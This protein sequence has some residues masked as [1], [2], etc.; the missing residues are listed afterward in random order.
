M[1]EVVLRCGPSRTEQRL[2]TYA[3]SY[4]QRQLRCDG[5]RLQPKRAWPE[6][7]IALPNWQNQRADIAGF[8]RLL[9]KVSSD[10][11]FRLSLWARDWLEG[12]QAAVELLNRYQRLLPL[13]IDYRPLPRLP[14]VLNARRLLTTS[15]VGHDGWRWLL[16]LNQQPSRALELAALFRDVLTPAHDNG[17]RAVWAS[18][19]CLGFSRQELLRAADLAAQS[20][21]GERHSPELMLLS[22]AADLTFFSAQSWHFHRDHDPVAVREQLT[23]RLA[24][25]TPRALCLALGTR[26]HPDVSRMLEEVLDDEQVPDSGVRTA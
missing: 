11:D 25:M 20:E 3:V 1:Q 23:T 21:A 10:G 22:D 17:T 12:L 2:A 6:L 18:L 7:S 16:R 14:E 9:D 8:D 5:I 4:L 13:P 19:G 26:Q 15:R 24:R